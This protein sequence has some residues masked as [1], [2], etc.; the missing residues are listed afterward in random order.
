[1]KEKPKPM[2]RRQPNKY[3]DFAFVELDGKRRYL[4]KYGTPESKEKY[5]QA[6]VEWTA[7]RQD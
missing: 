7:S 4:G 2:Y 6:L 3:G 1:M 5:R